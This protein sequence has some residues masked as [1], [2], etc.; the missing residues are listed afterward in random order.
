ML[1][2]ALQTT[3]EDAVPL[4]EVEFVIVDLETTGSAP[5]DAPITEIGAA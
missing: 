3:F 1:A 2:D 4:S 5:A